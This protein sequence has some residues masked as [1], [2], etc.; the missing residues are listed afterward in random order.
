[1]SDPTPD[2]SWA[3]SRKASS[4]HVQK[5]IKDALQQ[6]PA[7]APLIDIESELNRVLCTLAEHGIIR[8]SEFHVNRDHYHLGAGLKERSLPGG[9]KPGDPLIEVGKYQ[10]IIVS[11]DENCKGTVF[12]P[13]HHYVDTIAEV[14]VQFHQDDF[15]GYTHYKI[16]I[17][18]S[19]AM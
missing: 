8:N 2:W 14:R 18:N 12:E 19:V 13:E 11:V 5:T 7:A 16:V 3:I 17:T 1:M 4:L 9:A 15:V 6:L 10:G